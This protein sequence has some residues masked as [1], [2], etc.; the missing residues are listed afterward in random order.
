[1]QHIERFESL[2]GVSGGEACIL[3]TRIPVWVLV[4]GRPKFEKLFYVIPAEAGLQ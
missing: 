4:R 2:L 3:R 1:M